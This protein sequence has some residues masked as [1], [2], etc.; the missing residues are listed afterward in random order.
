MPKIEKFRLGEN[1]VEI[2]RFFKGSRLLGPT[3]LSGLL[4]DAPLEHGFNVLQNMGISQFHKRWKG[5][6]LA[7]DTPLFLKSLREIGR[8]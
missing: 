3:R 7:R 8:L 2:K 5:E 1:C 4:R 6:Y